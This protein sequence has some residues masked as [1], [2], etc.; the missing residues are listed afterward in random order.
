MGEGTLHGESGPESCEECISAEG[1]GDTVW[2]VEARW[3]GE[4][5]HVRQPDVGSQGLSG[6]RQ[7]STCAGSRYRESESKHQ[8]TPWRN[9]VHGIG[10]QAW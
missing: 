6:L 3:A 9:S 1:D 5:S 2:G 10:T 4:C 7:T 8:C